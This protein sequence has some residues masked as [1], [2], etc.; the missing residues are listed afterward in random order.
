VLKRIFGPKTEELTRGRNTNEEVHNFN[1]PSNIVRVIK[2]RRFRWV[3][4][5]AH[6]GEV[7]NAYKMFVGKP[8]RKTPLGRLRRRWKDNIKVD[9]MDVEYECGLD[10]SGCGPVADPCEHGIESSGSI[11]DGEISAQLSDY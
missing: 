10:S 2:L 4:H 8:E 3:E 7:R 6:M 1:V 5:L 11:T 9:L